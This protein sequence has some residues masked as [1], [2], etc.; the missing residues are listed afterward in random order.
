MSVH[1]DTKNVAADV[2][3]EGAGSNYAGSPYGSPVSMEFFRFGVGC[4]RHCGLPQSL[5]PLHDNNENTVA[6]GVGIED[7]GLG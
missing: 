7:T 2:G 5:I 4:C 1:Y 3:I 6:A